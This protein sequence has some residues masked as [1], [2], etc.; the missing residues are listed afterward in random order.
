MAT[1]DP[2]TKKLWKEALASSTSPWIVCGFAASAD[3]PFA[4]LDGMPGLIDWVVHGQVSR[5]L[6]D[7]KLGIGEAT[8]LPGDPARG[9]PSFLLF[10]VASGAPDP[11]A[12][13]KRVGAR[14]KHFSGRLSRQAEADF[15]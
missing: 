3:G 7:G 6:K 10:P 9:R 12:A 2:S 11:A 15:I 8:V 14:R 1:L 13:R 4:S 5:L